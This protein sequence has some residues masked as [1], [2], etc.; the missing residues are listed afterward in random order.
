M[1][2]ANTTIYKPTYIDDRIYIFLILWYT[3]W[4][5]LVLKRFN[6]IKKNKM[7]NALC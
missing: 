6:Q 5:N 3:I 4:R 7:N 2:Y 1:H